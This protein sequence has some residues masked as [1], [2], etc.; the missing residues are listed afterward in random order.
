MGW[1]AWAYKDDVSV[2][3]NK[4]KFPNLIHDC[5]KAFRE[6]V[7]AFGSCDA[8]V[9]YAGLGL[10]GCATAL[11]AVRLNPYADSWSD[12]Q[13]RA[14]ARCADWP[15]RLD[16]YDLTVKLWLAMCAKHDL[17]VRFSW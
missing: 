9:K 12:S 4:K 16:H 5:H 17:S 15:V 3:M 6:V 10:N 11:R 7:A 13:V 2:Y 1:D 8:S 14:Y